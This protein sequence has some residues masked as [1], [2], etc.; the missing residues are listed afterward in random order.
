LVFPCDEKLPPSV[1]DF[2]TGNGMCAM[3]KAVFAILFV[4]V[5]PAVAVI[6]EAQQPKKIARGVSPVIELN[7]PSN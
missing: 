6:V 3:R 1:V 2:M 4:A 5:L 7:S